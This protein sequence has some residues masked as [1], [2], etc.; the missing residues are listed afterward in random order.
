[1]KSSVPIPIFQE[2]NE[3]HQATGF[4]VR[5]DLPDFHLFTLEETYPATRMA[6]PPYR[7]GFYQITWLEQMGEA[8]MNF[9]NEA[10][11]G[12]ENVVVFSPPEQVLSW[13]CG[14]TER[15]FMLYFKPEL[16]AQSSQPLEATFPFFDTYALSV[17]P[18]LPEDRAAFNPQLARLRELF[19]SRHPYRRQQLAALTTAL[20]Y[21]CRALHERS[22]QNAAGLAAAPALVQRFRQMLAR[23]FQHHCSVESYAECLH[24]SADHLRAVVKKHTGRTVKELIAD[25]VILEARRLLNHTDLS[26]GEVAAHLQFS[27]PTHFARFFKRHT[28]QTPLEFRQDTARTAAVAA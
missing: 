8:T 10:L 23:C 7:R 1:M 9:E 18:L 24:V 25:R 4:P 17:L 14:G 11:A 6:M 26:V 13:V 2:I 5:T 15:G 21:D 16:F 28:Q 22:L 27:E 12:T 3:C 20:L 19:H